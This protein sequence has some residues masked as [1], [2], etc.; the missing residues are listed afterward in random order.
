MTEVHIHEGRGPGGRGA[1]PTRSSPVLGKI[2]RISLMKKC[3]FYLIRTPKWLKHFSIYTCLSWLSCTWRLKNTTELVCICCV[4]P[5]PFCFQI[6][7]PYLQFNIIME[8]FTKKKVM[9]FNVFCNY[10]TFFLS[11][12]YLV[13]GKSRR[14]FFLLTKTSTLLSKYIYKGLKNSQRC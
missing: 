12:Y 13:Y 3:M 6:D 5:Y 14:R 4:T 10:F 11:E 2:N 1:K 7:S 9:K 8:E